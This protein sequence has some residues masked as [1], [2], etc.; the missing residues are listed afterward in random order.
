VEFNRNHYFM[1]GL[2][3][4]LLG[5]QFRMVDSFVLNEK[6]TSFLNQQAAS[7]TEVTM[8]DYMPVPAAARK[9]VKPPPWLGYSLISVGSVLALHSFGMKRPGG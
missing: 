3:L 6:V 8:R 4:L 7:S 1:A 9:V 5:L 2:V